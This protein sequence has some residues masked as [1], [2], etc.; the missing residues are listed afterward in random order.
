MIKVLCDGYQVS[1]EVIKFSGG[2]VH[3]KLKVNS[4]HFGPHDFHLQCY[5]QNSDD[6]MEMLLVVDALRRNWS[7]QSISAEI[8]YVPYARQDRVCDHGEALG[9]SVAASLINMCKFDR[10]S[11]VDPH[12]DVIGALIDN[13]VI[14]HQTDFIPTDKGCD[15]VLAPDAGAIK[16][17]QVTA[18]RFGIPVLSAHKVR[19]VKTGDITHTEVPLDIANYNKVMVV[20]DICDGGRTFIEI[21]KV[22]HDSFN[23]NNEDLVLH[24]T[25]G[26]FSKGVGEL[27]KYYGE[28]YSPFLWDKD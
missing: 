20:D 19:D 10:V 17:A 26:I 7:I 13:V 25:H 14:A 15:V 1:K 11:I 6:F 22:L 3:P 8:P 9:A 23:F 4:G 28:I 24:V 18:K 21:G 16:K 5:I 27:Y 12:S 2:E